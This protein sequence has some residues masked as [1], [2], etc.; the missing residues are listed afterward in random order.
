MNAADPDAVA[1]CV[2]EDFR[3]EHAS[4]AGRASTGRAAYRQRLPGFLAAFPQLR[5]TPE[6]PPIAAGDRV[7]VPYLMTAMLPGGPLRVRG[8]WLVTIRNGLIAERVDY[9]DSG[10]VPASAG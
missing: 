4:P 9:W 8:L 6:A 5:Y 7:A 10:A 2:T 3:N 1:A